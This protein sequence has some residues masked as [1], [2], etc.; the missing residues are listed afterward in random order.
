MLI[1]L[2]STLK[3]T[4]LT[5]V[6]C[7]VAVALVSPGPASRA[8]NRGTEHDGGRSD[9][10]DRREWRISPRK[11]KDENPL[12]SD[13]VS[14]AKGSEI[15]LAECESCHG[16]GGRGDGPE[17][18]DLEARVPDLTTSGAMEEP[19]GALFW[20]LTLGRKP[21]PSY[22]KLLSN[23]DRWHVVNYLR[24]LESGGEKP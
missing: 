18:R 1:K 7:L 9:N 12:L 19:D 14:L 16:R 3:S 17:A 6:L 11:A 15:Y 5:P 24:T 22:G 10:Q 20:K 13:A 21:M 23:E 2:K 8:D 4:L